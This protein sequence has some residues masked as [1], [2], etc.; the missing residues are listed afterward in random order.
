MEPRKLSRVRVN[1]RLPPDLV[2][3]AKTHAKVRRVSFT[4]VVETALGD[5]RGSE[6]KKKEAANG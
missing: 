4:E 3:W 6:P 2:K 5:L 1:L